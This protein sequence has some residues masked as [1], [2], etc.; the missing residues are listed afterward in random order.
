MSAFKIGDEVRC[1]TGKYKMINNGDID[2][3]HAIEPHD[4]IRLT[5]S[6]RYKYKEKYFIISTKGKL[7]EEEKIP[8]PEKEPP[9]ATWKNPFKFTTVKPTA[10]EIYNKIKS[11][12]SSSLD[13]FKPDDIHTLLFFH[14]ST[15]E[16][17]DRKK[18]LLT[19]PE[20][21][22]RKSVV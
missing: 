5:N 11:A 1:L 19:Q 8:Q 14:L 4:F 15:G 10:I 3:V 6:K 21:I 16:W 13:V 12:Y 22:D 18:V 2:T 20:T 17:G 7:P 9:M